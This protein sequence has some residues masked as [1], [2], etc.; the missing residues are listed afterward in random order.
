MF[1]NSASGIKMAAQVSRTA[2][3]NITKLN[4]SHRWPLFSHDSSTWL[5][6]RSSHVFAGIGA[7]VLEQVEFG[8]FQKLGD[9][10]TKKQGIV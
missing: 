9:K 8:A 5:S 10:S 1:D 2:S 7:E 6:L 3:V 4:A